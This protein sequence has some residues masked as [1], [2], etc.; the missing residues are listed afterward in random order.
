MKNMFAMYAAMNMI[1]Q[2]EI[3]NTVL[4]RAQPLKICRMTGPAPSVV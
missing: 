1:L 3:L 4:L 2:W